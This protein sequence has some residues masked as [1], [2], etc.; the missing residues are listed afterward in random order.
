MVSIGGLGFIVWS[1]HMYTVGMDVDTRG[2]FTAAT[3]LIA[4]PTGIKIFSWIGSQ[5]EGRIELKTSMCY[6]VGF[7]ILFTIGGV[8]GVALANAG[9]DVSL[10]DT[11]YVTAH[12]HYVLSMGAVFGIL[13]GFYN[14]VNKVL[15]VQI[16]ESLGKVQFTLMFVGVN[17]TFM[18][19]HWLGLAGLPRRY[20]D[21]ADCYEAFNILSTLGSWLSMGATVLFIYL[22]YKDMEVGK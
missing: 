9:L 2:Y 15:E 4:V 8:T 12:F 11:Y 3:M 10:H 19:Q 13:A 16:E 20:I 22:V 5:W 14:W 6:T 21:Y 17:L 7:I 18:P 1:H